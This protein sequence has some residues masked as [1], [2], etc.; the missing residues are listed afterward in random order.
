MAVGVGLVELT[1]SLRRA[2]CEAEPRSDDVLLPL[3]LQLDRGGRIPFRPEQYRLCSVG[4][5]VAVGVITYATR[6]DRECQLVADRGG[7][8]PDRLRGRP[9]RERLRGVTAVVRLNVVCWRVA[10]GRRVVGL[11]EMHQGSAPKAVGDQVQQKTT[12]AV[13]YVLAHV[14]ITQ[15][16]AANGCRL[17]CGLSAPVGSMVIPVADDP[18]MGACL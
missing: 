4:H 12:T 11:E 10:G 3:R 7:Y 14:F 17:L 9:G 18:V 16:I 15:R 6:A 5:I 13:R 8:A 1:S 2:T